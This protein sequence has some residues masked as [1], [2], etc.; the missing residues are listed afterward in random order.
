MASASAAAT[1]TGARAAG[2]SRDILTLAVVVILGMIMTVLDLTIVNVAI[3]TLG[4]DLKTSI[5]SVQWVLTGYMLAFA[6]VIPVT[7]WAVERFGAKRVWLAALALFLAGSALAG[8]SWSAGSLIAFRVIQ[9]LGAGMIVP[10]GQTILAQAAGPQRM[11]R[12]MSVIGLPMML[13]PVFGPVIGGAILGAAGWRWIFFINL[14]VG[15]AAVAAAWRLLP[16]ARPQLG[17]R[18]DARG[19]LLLCPGIAVFLYGMSQ[20]GN[21]GDFA[22][23]PTIAAAAGLTLIGL[24]FWHAARRGEQALIDVS[25]LSRRGFAA[26]AA[27]NLLLMAGLFG[28]LILIPLYYQVVRHQGTLAT[29][30]LLAP[31]G[32]GAALSLPLAG[33][34]TDKAGARGV[35]VSGITVA[36]GAM[37]AYTQVGSRTSY[38]FL[39]GVLGVIGLGLGATVAPSMAAAFQALDRAETPRGTSALNAIQRIAG[40]VGTALFAIIL[41]HVITADLPRHPGGG[42]AI[43]A[44]S[45]QAREHAAATL[46]GA[47]G[48]T[49]WAA[50]A[51]TAAALIPA[52][53][54]PRAPHPARAHGSPAGG[55]ETASQP[56]T[57]GT[58]TSPIPAKEPR[59]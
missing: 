12:V 37:L 46:A 48:T 30:M 8:A 36:A 2:L 42:T 38:V 15:A 19:L 41:Q 18:L 47:F 53:L 26:A 6:A 40:A 39:A 10:T 49:F 35:T 25:L 3:P 9:G 11:G 4:A 14:P 17:Q 43:T 20:A 13:A 29:G 31:Q 55:Q 1:P 16:E 23:T 24:F 28:S 7:G 33:W 56:A 59:R 5:P 27:L 22:T 58:T 51:L 32:I 54:L 21:N 52:L 57:S 50:V 44:L 45:Q 34:L